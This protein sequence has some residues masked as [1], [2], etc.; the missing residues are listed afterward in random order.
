M[1]VAHTAGQARPRTTP[2][3]LSEAEAEARLRARPRVG[4]PASSR[5]YAS[6]VRTNVFTIFNGILAFFGA[7]TLAFGDWRD[8][9]FLGILLVNSAIGIGQEVRAKRSMDRL[10]AL[11]A[12]TARVLREGRTRELG[13]GE[14]V[15]DD[16]V[17]LQSGDQVVADGRLLESSGLTLDESILSGES[18]PVARGAGETVRSGSFAVEG[19]GLYRVE[20]VGPSSYAERIAAEARTYQRLR[21]PL[22]LAFNRLLLLL[23]AIML[24]LAAILGYSLWARDTGLREAVTTS[25]AAV[26]SLIPEG[27]IVLMSLTFAVGVIRMTRRGALAQRLNAVESLASADVV[28]LDKTGTLTGTGLR[29]VKLLPVAGANE[30]EVGSALGRLAAASGVRNPTIVA[31]A[32]AYGATTEAPLSEVPFSSRRRWSGAQFRD[33]A[34]VLGAPELFAL[35]PLAGQIDAEQRSGRRVVAFGSAPSLERADSRPPAAVEL[36]GVVVLGEPLRPEARATVAYFIEQGVEL[37]VFSGDNPA[38]VGAIAADAGIP[39]ERPPVDGSRLPESPGELRELLS[40]TSVIGRISP[41]GKRAC[42]RALADG[43][44]H[45][46]MVGDG[47]NDV[48]AMKAARLAIAQGSAVQMAK[49][50]ADIVLVRGDFAAVPQMVWE[51][52]KMLRNLQRVAKLY[53][54]KS[55]FAVFLILTVGT[56]AA[57]YP[58]LPRHFSLAAALTIG[59]PT[60]FLALAP[61]AGDWRPAGFLREVGRFAVPAGVAAGVG[62]VAS[63]HFAL[64]A[65]SL[66]LIEAR[67]VATTALVAVGLF[68]VVVLEGTAYRRGKL[69]M[70]LCA[71]LAAAYAAAL[72]VPGVRDFFE[73][74]APTPAIVAT[75]LIGAALAILGLLA[76]GFPPARPEGAE[77][78]TL[79]R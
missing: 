78:A 20:A 28:C 71:C 46:V 76:S 23:V 25:T 75:A 38:T 43:G 5:S 42:V 34:Y 3:G 1:E 40:D 8:A 55:A 10:A 41:E 24:P 11:V 59:I 52:R 32:N 60:F 51:G 30:A 74:A 54:S 57:A 61:S 2:A 29:V 26:V 65:L 13:V 16:L 77:G 14:V 64:N 53:V 15:E 39:Q 12:P 56:S 45:V 18:R 50:V 9:L 49:S 73:L 22:E 21:S 70:L 66:E 63:Y 58:L 44:H 19:F 17:Q 27:L 62:V 4:P 35:G 48:P 7:V 68:L 69:V 79:A 6:I 37:K 36:L 72:A 67:T 33:G 31:I 47:V